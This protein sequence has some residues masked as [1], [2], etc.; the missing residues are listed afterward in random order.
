[1][2]TPADRH[3]IDP[4]SQA[5]GRIEGRFESVGARFDAVDRR[6]DGVDRRL[7]RVETTMAT[8]AEL[9]AYMLIVGLLLAA[10]LAKVWS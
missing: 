10:I 8:K 1:M 7:D 3:P 4:I 9:R 2:S 5:L 6:L